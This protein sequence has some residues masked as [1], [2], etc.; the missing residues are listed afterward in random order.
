MRILTIV[1]LIVL[2]AVGRIC[3]GAN[4]RKRNT[5]LQTYVAAAQSD[6]SQP[7]A[8]ELLLLMRSLTRFFHDERQL[9]KNILSMNEGKCKKQVYT[10]EDTM[11]ALDRQV[12]AAAAQKEADAQEKELLVKNEVSIQEQIEQARK[13]KSE[14]EA[15]LEKLEMAARNETVAT[16]TSLATMSQVLSL[17]KASRRHKRSQA[18]SPIDK[19]VVEMRSLAGQLMHSSDVPATSTSSSQQK[20]PVVKHNRVLEGNDLLVEDKKHIMR[21]ALDAREEQKRD[22][23]QIIELMRIKTKEILEFVTALARVRAQIVGATAHSSR[24]EHD[25]AATRRI[26][27]HFQEIKGMLDT[28]CEI[29]KKGWRL[30]DTHLQRTGVGLDMALGLMQQINASGIVI[31]DMQDLGESFLQ[32]ASDHDAETETKDTLTEDRDTKDA[33][34]S[35]LSDA[36]GTKDDDGLDGAAV[37]DSAG[38]TYKS[39]SEALDEEKAPSTKASLNAKAP[40]GSSFLEAVQQSQGSFDGVIK[41]LEELLAKLET[42]SNM[43]KTKNTYCKDAYA[44]YAADQETMVSKKD[45]IMST[46]EFTMTEMTWLHGQRNISAGRMSLLRNITENLIERSE[47]LTK[48]GNSEK[49]KFS[50][51]KAEVEKAGNLLKSV[52]DKDSGNDTSSEST[53]ALCNHSSGLLTNVSKE[54]DLLVTHAN[55]FASNFT[56]FIST[57]MTKISALLETYTT[58]D[59][60]RA[61]ELADLLVN[62]VTN[63]A[64]MKNQLEQIANSLE[65]KKNTDEQCGPGADYATV[66]KERREKTIEALRSALE[67]L[68][69]SAEI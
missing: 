16:H 60:W 51:K 18:P 4:F 30:K 50:A 40:A 35:D 20:A 59:N 56:G 39:D 33:E 48:T 52:C 19:E 46:T 37:A 27:G 14:L 41:M 42:E 29:L 5:R 34:G 2:S 6:A 61:S 17:I 36:S 28:K 15:E 21:I 11:N 26:L 24:A 8:D 69:D 67:V 58:E 7:D 54:L 13:E 63:T 64:D 55:F 45:E 10:V 62:N 68:D 43:D 1:N 9:S 66:M 3:Q 22:S 25:L 38:I 12:E 49:E 47:N 23:K 53:A 44:Q 31:S 65:Q 57:V 32:F